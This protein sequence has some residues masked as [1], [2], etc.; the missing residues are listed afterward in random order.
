MDVTTELAALK[1]YMRVD[2]T[3]DDELIAEMANAAEQY[4][5]KAGVLKQ[6]TARYRL[7]RNALTL[8]YYEARSGA[9]T[10]P[11]GL[12]RM[13]IQLKCTAEEDANGTDDSGG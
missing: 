12:R 10:V 13:I 3:E 11:D 8:L 1:T 5:A 6:D 2:G 9:A 4:L 7:A